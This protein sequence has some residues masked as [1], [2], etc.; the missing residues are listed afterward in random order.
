MTRREPQERAL[1]Q[2]AARGR[3]EAVLLNRRGAVA[4]ASRNSIFMEVDGRL[5]TPPLA[6]G[7]LPGVLR[8]P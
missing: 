6:V 4:D 3:D 8:A 7:A 1:A 5:I 2:A